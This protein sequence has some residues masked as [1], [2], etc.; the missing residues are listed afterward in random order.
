MRA[1]INK[2]KDN[3]K[4]IDS[5]IKKNNEK[6]IDTERKL[7]TSFDEYN[8]LLLEYDRR[9]K[10]TGDKDKI[11]NLEERIIYQDNKIT[12]LENELKEKNNDDLLN[13]YNQIKENMKKLKM[14]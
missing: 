8:D 11:K 4:K 10:K 13:E 3:V 1:R 6:R 2:L 7:N 5:Y 14:N 9:K 12:E